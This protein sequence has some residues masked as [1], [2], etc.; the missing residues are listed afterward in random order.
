MPLLGK[1]V[2]LEQL[3]P[4]K[5]I[6]IDHA[7]DE[8]AQAVQQLLKR[9]H[10]EFAT[11]HHGML[12][13]N[14]LPHV[15]CSEYL[16]GASVDRL[17]ETYEHEVKVLDK[18]ETELDTQA[19]TTE[20][21]KNS[22]ND[23]SLNFAYMKFFD[24]ELQV[25]NGDWKE[26]LQHYLYSG[27]TPLIHGIT[28]GLGH[29][30]IHL[31]YAYEVGSKEVTTEA[32]SL[33]CTEYDPIHKYFDSPP[34]DNSTFKTKSILEIVSRVN[35]DTYFDGLFDAPGFI[36]I[37]TLLGAHEPTFLHYYNAWDTEDGIESFKISQRDAISLLVETYDK[38]LKH[39]FFVAHILTTSHALRI[40]LQ[41]VP[42]EHRVKLLRQWWMFGLL[43]YTAQLRL[44]I[45]EGTIAAVGLNGRDWEW[46]KEQAKTA[47]Y[48]MDSHFVKVLRAITSIKE[49]WGDEDYWCLKA[50][51]KFVDE[52]DGWT[53]FGNGPKPDE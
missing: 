35:K 47:K 5:V 43:V 29:P 9:N 50:A 27:E 15:L 22:L 31:A 20:S 14:H 51:V 11:L 45:H 53:G 7:Q 19:V 24:R 17:K 16:F 42:Q 28:G 23:K 1:A 39:D 13:H 3:P 30:L 12:F 6:Q 32:L 44:T 49:T 21:W 36:N 18:P 40:V 10:A 38:G 2:G 34:K 26:L 25:R 46:I 33:A 41:F 4:A 48:S 8:E 52:F 37:F